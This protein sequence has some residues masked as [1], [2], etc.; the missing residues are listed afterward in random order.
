MQEIFEKLD[1]LLFL[2]NCRL[3]SRS[4]LFI[5]SR[6]HARKLFISDETK[7]KGSQVTA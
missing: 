2:R 4:Y 5:L 7:R 1:F 6:Q 3:K